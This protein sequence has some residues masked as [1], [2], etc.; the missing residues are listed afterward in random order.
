MGEITYNLFISGPEYARYY[1]ALR[2]LR[3]TPERKIPRYYLDLQISAPSRIVQNF[4]SH[5][6]EIRSKKLKAAAHAGTPPSK[7][8]S[9]NQFPPMPGEPGLSISMPNRMPHEKRPVTSIN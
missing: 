1:F 2:G 3:N 5:G 4:S 7:R 9:P 8:G 6:I